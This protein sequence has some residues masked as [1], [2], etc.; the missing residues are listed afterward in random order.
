MTFDEYVGSNYDRLLRFATVLSGSPDLAQDLVHAALHNTMRHWPRVG[1]TE[2]PHAYVRRAVLNEYLSTQRR[3]RRQV[4]VG[5]HIDRVAG[6]DPAEAAAEQHALRALIA[7]LPPRQRAAIVL[8]YYEDLTDAEIAGVLRCR[9]STVRSNL[10]RA[11]AHLRVETSQ[12]DSAPATKGA[13]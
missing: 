11:L 4:L 7:G 9:E 13:S 8:R 1:S 3:A 10:A 5:D 6:P 2:H 12:P